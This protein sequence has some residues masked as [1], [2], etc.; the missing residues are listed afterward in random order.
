MLR[1]AAISRNYYCYQE[2]A[3]LLLG[4]ESD[5]RLPTTAWGRVVAQQQEVG[6]A[7]SSSSLPPPL[8]LAEHNFRYE[9]YWQRGLGRADRRYYGNVLT[10][11]AAV[12][13]RRPL[14]VK[15]LLAM[16]AL[17]VGCIGSAL[18]CFG[19]R[20]RR[21][22]QTVVAR[23]RRFFVVERMIVSCLHAGT[24]WA[25]LLCDEEEGLL[26]W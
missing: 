19:D 7:C 5:K 11:P 17:L 13:A 12:V 24:P 23:R 14:R 26:R 15:P 2:S 25:V 22:H 20:T 8:P 6:S 9:E 21:R 4:F 3:P 1:H 18:F 16:M 10:L